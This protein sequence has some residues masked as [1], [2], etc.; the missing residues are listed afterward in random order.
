M[1][2]FVLIT[3]R[4]VYKSLLMLRSMGRPSPPIINIHVPASHATIAP[5]AQAGRLFT[6]DANIG[7]VPTW[8]APLAAAT[9]YSCTSRYVEGLAAATCADTVIR[10][11]SLRRAIL[12]CPIRSSTKEVSST[13]APDMTRKGSRPATQTSNRSS[14]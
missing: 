11:Q 10:A 5:L 1:D 13:G 2:L 14:W 3:L 8:P 6:R 12:A 9:S 7:V 4:C